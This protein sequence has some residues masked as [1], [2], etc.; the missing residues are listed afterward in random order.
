MFA[1]GDSL[2]FEK[3]II[4][5]AINPGDTDVPAETHIVNPTSSPIT[6]RWIREVNSLPRG[7]NSAICDNNLCYPPTVDSASFTIPANG[8]ATMIT[9]VYPEGSGTNAQV[10]IRVL[11][12]DNRT[13]NA[14]ATYSFDM[15]SSTFGPN[16]PNDVNLYPNPATEDF[17]VQSDQPLS[18][19]V[20]TNMLGKVVRVYPGNQ[21]TYSISDLPNG[22]Y[23]ASMRGRN[24]DILKTI[25]LS[26][27]VTMP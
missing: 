4:T 1:Q 8:S 16:K 22:I 9:H 5:Q 19:I 10:T 27:R 18:Q 17:S 23:L 12:I 11:E 26:K 15:V 2:Y 6:A 14:V 13:N 7:W 25:R 24:G 21:E 20:V 3:T